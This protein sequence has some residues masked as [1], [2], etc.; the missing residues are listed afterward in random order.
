MEMEAGWESTEDEQTGATGNFSAKVLSP[1]GAVTPTYITPEHA[2]YRKKLIVHF[3]YACTRY[4]M[5]RVGKLLIL[6]YTKGQ[7][8]T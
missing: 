1:H 7:Q 2:V 5:L 8:V 6:T 3:L 4:L